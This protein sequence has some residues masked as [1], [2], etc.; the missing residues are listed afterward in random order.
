LKLDR[1]EK[2]A[3]II[4]GSILGV[5]LILLVFT[6]VRWQIDNTQ[7]IDYTVSVAD[8]MGAGEDGN[9]PKNEIYVMMEKT[10]QCIECG[11]CLPKCPYGL[12]I[13]E[14]LKKNYEDYKEV[15]AG[16]RSVR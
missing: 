1:S 7:E 2:R 15:L 6:V 16:N 12:N 3:I 8:R 5:L 10:K 13:P 9:N 14:L 11:A 4:F